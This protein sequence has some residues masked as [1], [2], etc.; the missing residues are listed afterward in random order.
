M[1]V[2]NY[3]FS[4]SKGWTLEKAEEQIDK[5]VAS[6]ESF[7]WTLNAFKVYKDLTESKGAKVWKVRALHVEKTKNGTLLPRR[8]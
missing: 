8:S 6:A 7:K 5:H 4:K 1:E 3:L 2:Q